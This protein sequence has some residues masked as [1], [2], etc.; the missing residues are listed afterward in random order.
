MSDKLLFRKI[1]NGDEEAFEEL[2]NKYYEPLVR[3]VWGYVKSEAIAEEIVQE[4]FMKVW[5]I[6][7]TLTIQRSV[8]SYIYS[9]GRNMSLNYLKHQN[10]QQEWEKE[11]KALHENRPLEAKLDDSLHNKM[12][13]EKVEEAIQ[14]LPERRRLIFILSR[15]K[16]MTYK[17]I[18]DFLDISENTVDT[19]IRRVLASLRERFSD[20]LIYLLAF[21]SLII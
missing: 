12:M 9:A 17:E 16:D 1:K 5:N 18:A 8:K 4:L 3:F 19:Q 14:N 20:L 6:S 7:S 11:K 21:F 13:L 15:H 2:F 10:T